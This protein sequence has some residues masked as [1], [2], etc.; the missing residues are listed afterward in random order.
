VTS[1]PGPDITKSIDES[2]V[3]AAWERNAPVWIDRVRAGADLFREAFNNPSFLRFLP[4]LAG[5]EIIDLGCGE[6]TNTRIFA[7]QGG[8]MTGVDLSPTMIEAAR[9]QEEQERLGITY[10]VASFTNLSA[11]YDGRF[12][13]AVSTMAL[14]DSPDFA[15]AAREIYRVLKPGAFF[16]FSVLH[17]CFITS[18]L[19]WIRDGSGVEQALAVGGYF[20]TESFVEHWRFSNDPDGEQFPKFEVPAFPRQL[21]TYVNGVIEAGFQITKILEPRPT[22]AM[23]AIYPWLVRWGRHAAIFLYLAAEKP[24]LSGRFDGNSTAEIR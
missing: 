2:D 9:A 12:D 20:E 10:H 18:G 21:A 16:A 7:R 6:G 3:L 5:K 22:A 19:R 23:S 1:C 24:I 14:M 8:R 4:D 13:A 15:G 17:P 11:F